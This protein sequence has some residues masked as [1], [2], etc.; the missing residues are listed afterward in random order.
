MKIGKRKLE[1]C[2]EIYNCMRLVFGDHVLP[3]SDILSELNFYYIVAT[4]GKK[5]F[6]VDTD[7]LKRTAILRFIYQGE[8]YRLDTQ[9]YPVLKEPLNSLFKLRSA[10]LLLV[11]NSKG[12]ISSMD[13]R[14]KTS[15]KKRK[16]AADSSDDE[17]DNI[18]DANSGIMV[19]HN[20]NIRQESRSLVVVSD[21]IPSNELFN[22]VG[23]I[24]LKSCETPDNL[25]KT[26][27]GLEIDFF[28]SLAMG[29]ASADYFATFFNLKT[30]SSVIQRAFVK[31]LLAKFWLERRSKLEQFRE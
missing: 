5:V 2:N 13:L 25:L 21:E 19:L 1:T 29:A 4:S 8:T 16:S 31:G 12:T 23:E 26:I 24:S 14:N 3:P 27:F 11:H 18:N 10:E 15:L 9:D 6:F 7:L 28:D 20:S 22:V 30:I 17:T